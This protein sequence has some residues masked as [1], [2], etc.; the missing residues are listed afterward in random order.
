MP[1][2]VGFAT[3]IELAI[4]MIDRARVAE[5]PGQIV[6][7][8]SAYGCSAP[9]R[10]YLSSIG[11]D[12]AV[13]I[14][15]DTKVWLLDSGGRRDGE[16]PRKPAGLGRTLGRKAFRRVTYR[17]GTKEK[18]W[19]RFCFRRVKVAAKPTGPETEQPPVWLVMEWPE[20][21]DAPTK[22]LLTTL[23]ARMTKKEI[24][25]IIKERW[26]TEQVYAELKGELGLDHFEGRSYPAWRNHISV[27]LICYAFLVAERSRR[28]SP[29]AE[30]AAGHANSGQLARHDEDSL[31]SLRRILARVAQR[32]LPRCPACGRDH[33]RP[34][35][36]CG[37]PSRADVLRQ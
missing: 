25:R 30:A 19:S 23:P 2:H 29:S 15:G 17:L 35:D 18:M 20:G 13:A 14:Q 16:R 34:P 27:V 37:R 6:L 24:V 5:L 7:A 33:P 28:F 10:D 4:D 22:Y 11:K 9:F 26:H 3:K 31:A 21:E 36:G 32:W 12:F 8:D 1:G